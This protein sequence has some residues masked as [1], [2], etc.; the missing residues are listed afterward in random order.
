MLCNGSGDESADK[1]TV[2]RL[3]TILIDL[4]SCENDEL[5]C[6]SLNLLTQMHFVEDT[7]LTHAAHCQLLT[8]PE[9]I[10]TSKQVQGMLPTLRHLLS[11]DC[12][13]EGMRK[14]VD[15]L[16][17]LTGYCTWPDDEE[18]HKENQMLLYNNG[19]DQ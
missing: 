10:E 8:A 14:I 1:E 18:P 13:V 16:K 6:H 19:N 12:D 15:L 4:S 3:K 7:L 2:M 9:V 17:K 11:V 5:V